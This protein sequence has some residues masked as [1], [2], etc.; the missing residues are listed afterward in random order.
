MSEKRICRECGIRSRQ[1]EYREDA[2]GDLQ[3][4]VYCRGMAGF[5]GKTVELDPTEPACRNFRPISACWGRKERASMTK[6]LGAM[7]EKRT[8]GDCVNRSR[9]LWRKDGAGEMYCFV[10]CRHKP[11]FEKRSVQLD[12]TEL[13]C[14]NFR[15]IEEGKDPDD[16]DAECDD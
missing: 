6:T 11:G 5:E 12:P 9:R 8:C 1:E 4:V 15:P 3:S 14:R 10:Y 16:E 13:G 7:S 2:H